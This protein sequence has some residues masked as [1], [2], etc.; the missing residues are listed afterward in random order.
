MTTSYEIDP[1]LVELYGMGRA[2]IRTLV[3]L[4]A[5][6]SLQADPRVQA[7]VWRAYRAGRSDLQGRIRALLGVSS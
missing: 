4:L 1:K 6:N 7:L 5:G 2:D 3:H